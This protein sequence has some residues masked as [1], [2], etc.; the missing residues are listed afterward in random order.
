MTGIGVR[1]LAIGMAAF[2]LGGCA[3]E[4]EKRL[5]AL[6]NECDHGDLRSCDRIPVWTQLVAAEVQ[7]R[8]SRAAEILGFA[9][10]MQAGAAVGRSFAP[11]PVYHQRYQMQY[12]APVNCTTMNLGGGM[13]ST[14]CY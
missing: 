7:Q 4:T 12:V 9:A 14:N 10:A 8:Q 1:W 2:I 3:S 13:S 5:T 6:A 11:P